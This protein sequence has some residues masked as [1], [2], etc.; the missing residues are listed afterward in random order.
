MAS[1][2]PKL[3]PEQKREYLKI[4]VTAGR[5]AARAYLEN[6]DCEGGIFIVKSKAEMEAIIQRQQTC[7]P[8]I[9]AVL[10][11]IPDNGRD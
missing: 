7:C 1:R 4:L 8:G 6:M 3:M 9:D 10:V 5:D 2:L 11:F